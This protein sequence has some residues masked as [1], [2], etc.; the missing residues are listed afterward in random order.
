MTGRFV[1]IVAHI[2]CVEKLTSK[3]K[4]SLF[5]TQNK[6]YNQLFSDLVNMAS[7]NYLQSK[8][9]IENFRGKVQ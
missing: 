3:D 1:K 4:L 7:T 9:D 8:L 5:S 6:I 2:M